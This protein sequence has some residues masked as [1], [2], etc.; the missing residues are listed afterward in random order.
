MTVPDL[1]GDLAAREPIFWT[2]TAAIAAGCTLMVG[3]AW[4]QWRRRR[5]SSRR[6][7]PVPAASGAPGVPLPEAPRVATGPAS[8]AP[9]AMPPAAETLA[10]LHARLR[11]AAERL[12][13]LA[14]TR[15]DTTGDSS[16]KRHVG[17]VEYVYKANA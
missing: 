12:E 15:R 3:A 8:A 10:T 16:L 2:A 1:L 14:E 5:G 9:D 13:A 17:A 7:D 11:V 4:W 6:L